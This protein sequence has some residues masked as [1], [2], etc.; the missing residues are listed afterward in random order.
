[1]A[2]PAVPPLVAV[3]DEARLAREDF[4][5]RMAALLEAALPALWLRPGATPAGRF[6]EVALA[7]RQAT[8]ARGAELWVGDRAD[9]ARLSAADRLHLPGHG[10]PAPEARRILAAGQRVGRSVHGAEEARRAA[11]ESLD[12]FV[13]GTI[14]ATDTHP[15][16]TP[17]GPQRIR[18]VAAALPAAGGPV[19][20]AIGGME[21]RRVAAALEA[22]AAGVVALRALWDAPRPDLAVAEFLAALGA[23]PSGASTLE[24]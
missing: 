23:D 15:D 16:V 7:A 17:A 18:D 10:L 9:V 1:M 5:E 4:A 13:V 20:Y 8:A 19:L 12:H 6:L 3:V 11:S 14:F 24:A 22:G 21:P 2:D